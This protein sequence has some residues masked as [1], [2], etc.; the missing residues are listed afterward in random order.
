[1]STH[2]QEHSRA[3]AREQ[4][5]NWENAKLTRR[6]RTEQLRQERLRQGLSVRQLAEKAGL[7]GSTISKSEALGYSDANYLKV[8]KALGMP[9]SSFIQ[10]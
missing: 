7:A 6:D 3:Y 4:R 8:R 2:S 9:D 5:A 10:E 1:M